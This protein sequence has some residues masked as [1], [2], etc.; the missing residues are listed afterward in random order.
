MAVTLVPRG[1][2]RFK[3]RNHHFYSYR[4]IT[5]AILFL[6]LLNT[7]VVDVVKMDDGVVGRTGIM[8]VVWFASLSVLMKTNSAVLAVSVDIA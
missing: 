1:K 3:G 4:Q 8:D 7:P 6:L 2:G 5:V